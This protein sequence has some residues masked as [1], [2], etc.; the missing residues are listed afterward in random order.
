MTREEFYAEL[1]ALAEPDYRD[2]NAGL[3]PGVANI[4]GVRMPALRRIAKRIA[5]G[6][7]RAFLAAAR[8]ESYEETMVQALVIGLAKGSP[9]EILSYV[10]AF[11][12][13]IDN[14][15]VC[16]C[17]CGGLKLAQR[18]PGLVWDFVRPYFSSPQPFA[19]RFALVMALNHYMQ[20]PYLDEV[21]ELIDGVKL[22]H[23]YV[24]M[25]AAWAVSFCFIHYP[26]RTKAY[27]QNNTLDDF[28]YSKSLSKI[29]ESYRVS[30]EDKEFIRALRKNKA[31]R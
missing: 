9:E 11:V 16:D 30:P 13:K 31:A 5:A 1:Y 10:A 19:V 17:F 26:G 6:D 12:P 25:A 14:W 15:A 20:E 28:T 3:L 2:F 24:K 21:L 18:H 27:L 4:L 7:W 8:E 22:D 23:H 29:L